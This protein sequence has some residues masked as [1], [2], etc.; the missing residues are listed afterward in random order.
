MIAL[1]YASNSIWNM[2]FKVQFH[3]FCQ[4]GI[5]KDDNN[6]NKTINNFF[7]MMI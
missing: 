2:Q 7:V 3:K 1:V 4:N 6:N 5:Y